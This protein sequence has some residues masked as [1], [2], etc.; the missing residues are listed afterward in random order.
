MSNLKDHHF[1]LGKDSKT[2]NYRSS[3]TIGNYAD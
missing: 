3:T 2:F 1:T